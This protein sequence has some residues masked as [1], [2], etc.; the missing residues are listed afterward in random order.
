L[1]D[2]L[3]LSLLLASHHERG[4]Y[5]F[6]NPGAISHNE[7]LTLYRDIVDPSFKWQNFTLEEQSHVIKAGRS[8]CILDTGK[9]EGKMQEFGVELEDMEIKGGMRRC[10]ERMARGEGLRSRSMLKEGMG[11][12]GKGLWMGK[13]NEEGNENAHHFRGKV[14]GE[15]V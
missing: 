7:V 4:V 2:L 8:N 10:F 12:E 15:V 14:G 13:E 6:T 3:P 1:H 9:L 5:N 11:M